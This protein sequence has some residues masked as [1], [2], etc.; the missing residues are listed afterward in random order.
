MIQHI[1]KVKG[2]RSLTL[3]HAFEPYRHEAEFG[4]A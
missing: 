1:A 4:H 2:M 3:R